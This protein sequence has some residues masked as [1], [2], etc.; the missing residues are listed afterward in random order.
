MRLF[1]AIA[2]PGEVREKLAAQAAS[3][4]ALTGGRSAPPD[5]YH[6]TLAFLGEVPEDRLDE[7]RSAMEECP[8]PPLEL[9]LGR[10]GR[11]RQR[12]GDVLWREVRGGNAL[13]SLQRR[14]VRSLSERGFPVDKKEY[15]PHV[16]LAR[17]AALPAGPAALPEAEEISFTAGGMRLMRSEPGHG[18]PKYT[19][20]VF[21][22]FSGSGD[23]S[24]RT[25]AN[26][27]GN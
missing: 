4:L 17:A 18:A 20:L 16:T 25:L 22:P 13:F 24:E 2:F 10:W 9:T 3:V 12:G 21:V 6:L 5:L 15:V 14:L 1:I 26:A 27:G 19:E 23:A 7:L 8:S 11:F